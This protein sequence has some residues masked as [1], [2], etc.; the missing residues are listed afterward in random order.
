MRALLVIG[1]ILA[2]LLLI[3]L[4]RVGAEAAYSN[5]DGFSLAIRIG[6]VS[7]RLGNRR[8]KKK[9][10][11]S[12]EATTGSEKEKKKKRSSGPPPLS[13]ILRVS[14]NAIVQ[15]SRLV[16]RQRVEFLR[17]RVTAALPDPADAAML[18]AA[19]GTVI[20]GLRRIGGKKLVVS[21]LRADVDFDRTT[22]DIDVC[23]RSSLRIGELTSSL[24][25]IAAGSLKEFLLYKR[26]VKHG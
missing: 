2:V 6:H 14:E 12:D 1:V 3:G 24:L 5:S 21:D 11:K 7:F 9:T 8:K 17:L 13:L 15:L 16:F 20:D 25:R 18:Y 22:P 4:I 23:L 19:A 10:S 26:S